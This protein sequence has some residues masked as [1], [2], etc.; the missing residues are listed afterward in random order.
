MPNGHWEDVAIADPQRRNS[1]H[2]SRRSFEDMTASLGGISF[3]RS[4]IMSALALILIWIAATR[5]FYMVLH[6]PMYGYAN[7]F[8]VGRTAACLNLWPDFPGGPRDIGH[9]DAP[10]E[11]HRLVTVAS[12]GCYPSAEVVV[13]W[14]AVRLDGV[15]RLVVGASDVVDMRAIGLFKALLLV[16]TACVVSQS[17]RRRP[18]IAL[19]HAATLLLVIADPPHTLYL[20]RFMASL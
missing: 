3:R 8:D 13:D 19:V 1:E 18:A 10:I 11:T 20:N 14:I 9:F 12:Q 17:L 15:R 7:Q 5:I 16:A 6:D 2:E 4:Q